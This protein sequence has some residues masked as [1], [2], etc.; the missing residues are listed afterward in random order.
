MYK[1]LCDA[2]VSPALEGREVFILWPD[3]G[4]WYAAEVDEVRRRRVARGGRRRQG[5]RSRCDG[6]A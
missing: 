4:T 3:D 2:D 1:L 5:A 6:F